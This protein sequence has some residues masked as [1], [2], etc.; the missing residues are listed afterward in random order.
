MADTQEEKHDNQ[1][2]FDDDFDTNGG[3]LSAASLFSQQHGYTYDD[4]ILLP[5]HIDFATEDI[6]LNSK[7]TRNITVQLPFVSSPMDTVTEH[8]MAIAMALNGGIG[9]IHCN[10]PIKEQAHEVQSC[11]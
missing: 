3:G 1:L 11:N 2:Q 6:I 5:G 4:L 7:F 9:A 8:K 10:M